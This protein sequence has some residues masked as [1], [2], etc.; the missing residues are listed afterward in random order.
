L[1]LH[2]PLHIGRPAELAGDKDTGRVGDTVGDN[3]LL[4]LVAEI[5]LDGAAE[6]LK[7]LDVPTIRQY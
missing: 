7:V 4:D 1:R 6:T 2:D 3:Y 5:L